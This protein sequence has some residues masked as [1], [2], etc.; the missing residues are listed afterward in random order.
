MQA[1]EAGFVSISWSFC[2]WLDREG[3]EVLASVSWL[4]DLFVATRLV[5]EVFL[6][7]QARYSCLTFLL[8]LN[9]LLSMVLL[10]NQ[11]LDKSKEF[12]VGDLFSRLALWLVVNNSLS[13]LALECHQFLMPGAREHMCFS[14]PTRMLGLPV[15]HW[16]HALSLVSRG[17]CRVNEGFQV[18]AA[19]MICEGNLVSVSV[20]VKFFSLLVWL[21]LYLSGIQAI[22]S[23]EKCEK[24]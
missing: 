5:A 18:P 15:R 22:L 7:S 19:A 2:E 3:G 21:T 17:D 12:L 13:S 6:A 20:A 23:R 11:K 14:G 9:V 10:S 4:Y 24:S 1:Q 16:W 8:V